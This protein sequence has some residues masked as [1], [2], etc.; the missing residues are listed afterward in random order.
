MKLA[1][2]LAQRSECQVR[3]EEL[4]KRIVRNARVQEGEQPG[5]DPQVL[6]DEV[7]RIALRLMELVQTINRT[8]VHTSF[9]EGT[10]IADAVAE[11]DVLGAKRDLLMAVG[12][13][14]SQRDDRSSKSEVRFI[15]ALP[16]GKIQRQVDQLAKRYRE[17]DL[18]IQELTWK[19]EVV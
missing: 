11:R 2:A 13:A 6:L 5:E 15:A 8:N 12:D 1:E 10:T 14:A 18:K 17:I 16:V 7:D 9:D 3:M 4:K 19:T